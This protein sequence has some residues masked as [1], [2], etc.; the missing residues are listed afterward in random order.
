MIRSLRQRFSTAAMAGLLTAVSPYAFAEEEREGESAPPSGQTD[1]RIDR[2]HKSVSD[3]I[4]EKADGLD[5]NLD[6]L[7]TSEEMQ[8]NRTFDHM[9]IPPSA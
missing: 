6:R 1:S 7:I 5:Q 9:K 2:V 8:R 3:Y 4:I